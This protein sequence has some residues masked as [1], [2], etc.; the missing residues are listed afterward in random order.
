MRTACEALTFA[1]V[2]TPGAALAALGLTVAHRP[3]FPGLRP[4]PP[5][6]WLSVGLGRAAAKA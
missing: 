3:L 1:D 6:A 4:V 5:P 2:T